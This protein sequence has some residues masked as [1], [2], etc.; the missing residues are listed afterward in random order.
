MLTIITKPL[1]W[2]EKFKYTL[3]KNIK[4]FLNKNTF[5]PI[6]VLESIFNWLKE[7]E[8]DKW[9]DFNYNINPKEKDIYSTVF[10][11]IWK[12][13]LKYVIWLKKRWIIKKIIAWP[14]ISVPID[15]KDVFFHEEVDC[16]LTPSEWVKKYFLSLLPNNK[17]IKVWAAGI[18]ILKES[19]KWKNIL[20]FYKNCPIEILNDIKKYLEKNNFTFN[21]LKYWTFQ[22]KD[23]IQK[24]DNSFMMI[25][26]QESETQ[27]I[28]LAEAWMK[29]I[30]TLVWNRWYWE[31]R[32]KMVW[33]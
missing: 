21:V 18:P 12:E 22:K 3:K 28:A 10:V 15:D 17:R 31:Y 24:L 32:N 29:N 23:Y 27:S 8:N 4:N 25:Y 7:L 11:P 13:S 1:S 5:W 20:I 26:L 30:P 14:N 2:K 16:I 6:Y 33:W 19:L 9:L